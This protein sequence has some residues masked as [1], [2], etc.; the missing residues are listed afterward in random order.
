MSFRGQLASF[1]VLIVVVPMISVAVVLF[2]LIDRSEE[3]KIG[4]AVSAR[5]TATAGMVEDARLAARPAARTIARDAEVG[6]ALRDGDT[7]ALRARLDALRRSTGATRVL[8]VRDERILTEVG[9]SDAVWPTYSDLIDQQDRDFG[10]L[11]VSVTDADMWVRRARPVAGAQVILRRDGDV[12]ASTV[13]EPPADFV[14]PVT[15]ENEAGT[16]VLNGVEYRGATFRPAD[17]ADETSLVTI[18]YEPVDETDATESRLLTLG[19]LAGFFILAC[20]FAL[21]VS[22][23]LQEKI[24]GLL[25]A[26]RD[27]RAGQYGARVPTKGRDDFAA[28]GHEFNEMS[29]ELERKIGELRHERSRVRDAWDRLGATF[30]S[31]LDRPKLL[32]N[33]VRAAHEG[34]DA[35]GGRA[36][37]RR[38]PGLP[39][40][41]IAKA[42]GLGG[43]EHAIQ[44][45]E[46]S[47]LAGGH[48][49]EV[50]V[51]DVSAVAQPLLA[52]G[53][54]ITGV[55]AVARRG[56]PFSPE[57]RDDLRNLTIQAAVSLANVALHETA[58]RLAV[59][60][61][62]TGLSNRRRFDVTLEA[63]VERARRFGQPLALVLLDLDDFKDVNDAH[64]HQVGDEVLRAVAR[65]LRDSCR[66]VDEP[67][68]Y[69]GEELAVVMPNTDLDGAEH[70]AERIRHGVA[71]LRVPVPDGAGTLAITTSLGVATM[72]ASASDAPSLVE[73][74]DDALYRAKRSGKNRTMLAA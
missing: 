36:M 69:G 32:E 21:Y 45:A 7:V 23:S 28:L 8:I 30:G 14:A 61:E 60:D 26:V 50:S 6:A 46:A 70:L 34:L 25:T 27:V 73:A 59:T 20:T 4:A 33:L 44:A 11:Q 9:R 65:V 71:G 5:Q 17:F 24:A 39:L 52:E 22:R 40:E 48:G 38:G 68:R 16:A 54:G 29:D 66:E 63:E 47:A 12:L 42:G 72:P 15:R 62:L 41:E 31:T 58:E 74:A 53:G 37:L 49:S 1:F 35:D 3:G 43:L 10:R 2:I 55:V 64:G 19:V 57:E 51:D 67:A 18:L 13:G 56:R